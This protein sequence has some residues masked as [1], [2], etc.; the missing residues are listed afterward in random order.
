[1][2]NLRHPGGCNVAPRALVNLMDAAGRELKVRTHV[3]PE[4]LDIT[5]PALFDYHL[6]F[7]HG[8]TAFRLT[9]GERQQLKL[10]LERGGMLLADSICASRAFSESFRRE[11]AAIFPDRK[12]ERIPVGDP[13]LST[14]YGGFDLRQVSRRDPETAAPGKPLG[15]RGP[16]G[17]ARPGGDQAGRPLGRGLFA[18]RLELR[19]GEAELLGVSA[20]TPATTPPASG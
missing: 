13:L 14:A 11:M 1:M 6:V 7:M 18:I 9:D 19:L 3:R 2:A 17:P 16:Q 15:S 8:R 4:L 12:L 10:Y 20:A 5:D